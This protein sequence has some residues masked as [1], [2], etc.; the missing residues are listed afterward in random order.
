MSDAHETDEIILKKI[1]KRKSAN[2][3]E[4]DF[5]DVISIKNP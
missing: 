5:L 1:V 2:I 3:Q 4:N